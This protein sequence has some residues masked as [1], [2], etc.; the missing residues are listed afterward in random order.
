[1]PV[2]GV[3]NDHVGRLGDAGVGQLAAGGG[4]H[5]AEVAEVR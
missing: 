4:Q 2:A 1:M 3:G 5:R